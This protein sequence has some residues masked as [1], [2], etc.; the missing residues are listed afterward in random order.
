MT[1]K[2]EDKKLSLWL[3]I[4]FVIFSYASKRARTIIYIKNIFNFIFLAK[5]FWA[6]LSNRVS[7]Q[8][9]IHRKI[10]IM[11]KYTCLEVSDKVS[12]WSIQ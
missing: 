1:Q 4:I 11:T 5:Q 7:F 9:M 3:H 6:T 12:L 10:I 8:V 2:P